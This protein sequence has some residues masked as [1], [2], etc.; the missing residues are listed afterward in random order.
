MN[1]EAF[2]RAFDALA[3]SSDFNEKTKR[4]LRQT[5]AERKESTMNKHKLTTKGRIAL[6]AAALALILT[7]TAG[8]AA[9]KFLLPKEAQEY[10]QMEDLH[11]ADVLA[12]GS[13]DVENVT[14]VKQAVRSEGHTIAFEAIVE[15]TQLKPDILSVL[16]A[17]QAGDLSQ[18]EFHPENAVYAVLT[19]VKDDGGPVLGLDPV[20]ELH[21]ELGAALFIQGIPPLYYHCAG[22]FITIENTAYMF[23]PLHEAAIFADRELRICVYGS[24][25]PAENILGM[26]EDG[27]PEFKASYHGIKAMFEVDLDDSLA[28][29]AAVAALEEQRPF[30]PTEWEL[31][32]GLAG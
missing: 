3:F 20:Y 5:A 7:L 10:L 6:I 26:D 12:D 29:H 18:I 9:V 17:A 32:H 31:N 19:V 1:R 11:I 22:Q 23:V 25:A 21:S 8:A 14:A 24:F 30:L 4:L 16:A 27:L 13:F 15:G 28:D 2:V